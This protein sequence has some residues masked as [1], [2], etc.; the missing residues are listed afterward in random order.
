MKKKSRGRL[1]CAAPEFCADLLYAGG[2][3][4]PDPI[5]WF[6]TSEF[7]A[8]VVSILEYERACVQAK[9]NVRVLPLEEFFTKED[10]FK[11]DELLIQRIS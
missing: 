9:K 1:I 8:I 6:Q 11:N 5:V 10:K 3:N 7:Q 4:A 2:F